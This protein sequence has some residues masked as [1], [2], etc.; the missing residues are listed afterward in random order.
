MN[1][2]SLMLLDK[3][4]AGIKCRQMTCQGLWSSGTTYITF[5]DVKV[6]VENLIGK[7]NMGFKYIMYNF[8]PE[9]FGIVVQ[10][11]RSARLCLE[12]AYRYA[13]KRKT[14]GQRL[15]ESPVIRA[16]IG[17]MIRQVEAVQAHM[18]MTAY[19]LKNMSHMEAM[20]KMA[21]PI[22]FL[23]VQ[24]TQV[25]EYCAREAVQIFGGLGFTRGGQGGVVER[26]YREVRAQGIPY[27]LI[28]SN[29]W[30]I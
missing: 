10:T 19:A 27:L 14:F 4:M 11:V 16:K 28:F 23:K 1:G 3:E 29:F 17:N 15:I 25:F 2:I 21:G 6:P 30:W 24:S 22:A 8:N 7:E 9:R 26:L 18:E 5:E 20:L 12:E 13:H